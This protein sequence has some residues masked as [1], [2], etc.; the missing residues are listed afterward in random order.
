MIALMLGPLKD[1]SAALVIA[2]PGHELRVYKWLS[3]ARPLV[4][5][6]TDG[7]GSLGKSR[8]H[9][10]LRILDEVG[11][12]PGSIC[13]DMTDREMY[14]A[15]ID[16]KVERL[17]GLAGEL[18]AELIRNRIEYVIGDSVEGYNPVHDLC[19]LVI[20]AAVTKAGHLGYSIEN[21][22]VSLMGNAKLDDANTQVRIAVDEPTL[23]RKLAAA[24]N[25]SELTI[26]IDRV[27]AL[28]GNDSIR[29]EC[30]RRVSGDF[31]YDFGDRRPYYEE[32]GEKQVAAGCYKKVLRFRQHLQP[33]AAAL[34][35]F[36]VGEE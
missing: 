30:F 16:Q 7:S 17:V 2:H 18:T 9:R 22:E 27:L 32:Y 15:I 35:R 31:V 13:G 4:F 3:L 29:T 21:F 23:A 34:D 20:N 36:S 33:L 6:L 26:E 11:A 10:T 1:R 24:Q 12:R 28:Q 14:A 19:R 8:L 5:V 25:Y